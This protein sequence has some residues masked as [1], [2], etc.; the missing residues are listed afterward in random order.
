MKI[1]AKW[2]L[3]AALVSL[4]M[5][6]PLAAQETGV[7]FMPHTSEIFGFETVIPVGW[8]DLG[9]GIFARQSEGDAGDPTI[10]AQQAAPM[11]ADAL[12]TAILPQLGL[13]E[14]PESVGMYQGMTLE[15]TLYHIEVESPGGDLAVDLALAHESG[16]TYL[17]LTQTS[18]EEYDLLHQTIFLPTLD[19]FAPLVESVEDLPYLVEDVTFENGDITL[20]GT[21][22]LPDTDGPHPAV[23][24]DHGQR[25]AGSGRVAC[26]CRSDQALPPDRRCA[27]PR[28]YR[29]A[30]LR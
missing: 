27:D 19:A 1:F 18:P 22:T 16:T 5:F 13:T 20:A 21:L 11:A 23:G 25:S 8:A 6:A 3:V 7:T 12:L 24:A 30:A 14:A 26:A 9:Q 17:V 15:W 28:R 4:S 2:L 29:G 10:I